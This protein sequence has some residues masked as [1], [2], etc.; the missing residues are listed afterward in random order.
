VNRD[1]SATAANP[2]P[3]RTR[4]G[5]LLALAGA[6]LLL[7]FLIV[8]G[9]GDDINRRVGRDPGPVSRAAT[10][11]QALHDLLAAL[12]GTQVGFARDRE[13]FTDDALLILTPDRDTQARHLAELLNARGD[14]PTLVILPK[15][16]TERDGLSMTRERR[17][18]APDFGRQAAGAVLNDAVDVEYRA[19]FDGRRQPTSGLGLPDFAAID[20]PSGLHGE[21]LDPVVDIANLGAI[22]ARVGNRP[23]WIVADPDIASNHGLANPANA[24]AIVALLATMTGERPGEYTFDL[25]LHYR[26]GDRNLV[27]LMFT[28]PFLAVT[29][30]LVAAALLAGW[31]SVARFGPV[32]REGRALAFGKAALIDTVANLTRAAGKARHGGPRRAAA[33]AE[34][35]GRRLHAPPGVHGEALADWIEAQR[36]G[37]RERHRSLVA[38]TTETELVAAAQALDD[39]RKEHA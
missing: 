37:Y 29:L 2:V 39:W 17:S 22:V 3:F 25:T 33:Q 35:I 34:R 32:A 24:R 23:L 1:A 11:F 30:S 27:K 19:S 7:G 8:S 21:A 10:G 4:T 31:A 12:P 36:P 9:F 5:V 16:Q 28:P 6:V 14:R 20:Q 18:N 38:A 15:W 13:A 26:P